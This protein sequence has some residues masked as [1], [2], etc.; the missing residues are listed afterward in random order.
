MRILGIDPGCYGAFAVVDNGKPVE[1]HDMPFVKIRRGKSDK[2]EIEGY[3]LANALRDL[4]IDKCYM[5]QVTGMTGQAAST[6]FNFGR[7]CGVIEGTV[8]ALGIAI[9]MVPPGTWKKMQGIKSGGKAGGKQNKDNSRLAA[10]SRWP[11]KSEYFKRKKDDGR[12]EACLIA[13]YGYKIENTNAALHT[14]KGNRN[15]S[16]FD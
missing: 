5:E 12:A 4:R 2:A 14:P 13:D 8:K 10:I 1:I 7:A 11:S 15:V 16:L 3:A 6:S 9:V